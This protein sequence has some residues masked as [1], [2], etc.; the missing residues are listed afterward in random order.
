MWGGYLGASLAP[1]TGLKFNDGIFPA[2]GTV[3]T[4]KQKFEPA[5]VGGLKFG[6]FLKSVP[7]LGLEAETNYAHNNAGA[8]G[9]PEPRRAGD[10]TTGHRALRL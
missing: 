5:V 1:S 2:G 8:T 9:Y 4:S 7:Y 6:Y 3:D 10:C